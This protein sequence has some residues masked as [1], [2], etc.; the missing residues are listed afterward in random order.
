MLICYEVPAPSRNVRHYCYVCK[1]G[2]D[3]A[4]QLNKCAACN[5]VFLCREHRIFLDCFPTGHGLS[6]CCRHTRYTPGVL[7]WNPVGGYPQLCETSE[8]KEEEEWLE[9]GGDR[10]A[11]LR[12]AQRRKLERASAAA[13]QINE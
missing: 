6:I 2:Q 4:V 13:S 8:V 12:K 10:D 9:E 1:R 3:A 5:N 11:V 7:S